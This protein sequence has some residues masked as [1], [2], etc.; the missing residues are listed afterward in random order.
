[1]TK[2]IAVGSKLKIGVTILVTTVKMGENR[3]M[4]KEFFP[5]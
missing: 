3:M 4:A 2:H 1:M 5:K